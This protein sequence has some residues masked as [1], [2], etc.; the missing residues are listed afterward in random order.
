MVRT[1]TEDEFR[2]NCIDLFIIFKPIVDSLSIF[3]GLTKISTIRYQY[4][5]RNEGVSHTLDM[6]SKLQ[7]LKQIEVLFAPSDL[8]PTAH[9]D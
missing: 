5:R 6:G 9:K 1:Q 2:F 4:F 3:L 7:R 8:R